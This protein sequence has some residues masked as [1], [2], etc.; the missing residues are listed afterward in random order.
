MISAV[1]VEGNMTRQPRDLIPIRRNKS[2]NFEILVLKLAI[3]EGRN[4]DISFFTL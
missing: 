3:M 4:I 1:T 2:R